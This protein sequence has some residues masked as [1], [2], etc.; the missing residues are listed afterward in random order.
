MVYQMQFW[1]AVVHQRASTCTEYGLPGRLYTRRPLHVRNEERY[2]VAG[3]GFEARRAEGAVNSLHQQTA[4]ARDF[5]DGKSWKG[6]KGAG[7][8]GGLAPSE[9]S[10]SLLPP[11][12]RLKAPRP[13]GHRTVFLRRADALC[14][15]HVEPIWCTNGLFLCVSYTTDPSGV[16]T[17]RQTAFR[18]RNV[19]LVYERLPATDWGIFVAGR[20]L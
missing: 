4:R 12:T 14:S 15:V 19:L 18:T 16:R 2:P 20:G 11:G 3:T 1:A 9:K 7:V 17:A 6:L 10:A 5:C 8:W 13:F